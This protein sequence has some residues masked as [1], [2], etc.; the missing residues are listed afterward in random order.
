M[1]DMKHS[2]MISLCFV[3]IVIFSP[4]IYAETEIVVVTENWAPYNF[5]E[6]GLVKGASTEIVK[7]VLDNTDLNY[8]IRVYP[9]ARAYYLRIQKSQAHYQN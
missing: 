3:F 5:I 9:W 2:M 8:S 7:R 4:K 6:N 1:N